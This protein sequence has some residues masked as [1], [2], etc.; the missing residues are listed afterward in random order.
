[1][2][3]APVLQNHGCGGVVWRPAG[4][5]AGGSEA[6]RRKKRA[7]QSVGN[8]RG[9]ARPHQPRPKRLDPASSESARGHALTGQRGA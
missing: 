3:A 9:V 1:M 2:I 8:E 6:E 7:E 4:V 5:G